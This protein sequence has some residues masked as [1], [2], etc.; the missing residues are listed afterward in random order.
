MQLEG[1]HDHGGRAEPTRTAASL[2][3]FEILVEQIPD[4]ATIQRTAE[5]ANDDPPAANA[6][7]MH[8]YVTLSN[9]LG[10]LLHGDHE[11][12]EN[13]TFTTF[14]AWAAKS[15]RPEVMLSA[16]PALTAPMHLRPVRRVFH[17]M[18]RDVLHVDH[19]I[20]RNI[21][22][23]Q[24]AIFEEIGSTIHKLIRI[25]V[26]ELDALGLEQCANPDAWPPIWRRY[27]ASLEEMLHY[28]NLSRD[29]AEILAPRSVAS[30]QRAVLPYF[31]VMMQGLSRREPSDDHRVER[32]E[33][34]LMGNV[35]LLA[36]EQRRL[37]PLLK[38]NF[39]YIP[40]AVRAR[41]EGLIGRRA[42]HTAGAGAA[43]KAS[44]QGTGVLNEAFQIAATRRFYSMALGTEDL[45]FGR[46]L[47]LPPPSRPELR[48][49]EPESDVARYR[50]GAFFPRHLEGLDA[51]ATWTVWQRHDRSLG[52]GR[53][54]AINNW[55]RY[56]ERMSFL[57]NMFR[58]RQQLSELYL[59]PGESTS[60]PAPCREPPRE[61]LVTTLTTR[62]PSV[63]I[64]A[65]PPMPTAGFLPDAV[66]D[67]L[68]GIG[69]RPAEELL[70]LVLKDL[71]I[72]SPDLDWTQRRSKFPDVLRVIGGRG[73]RIDPFL[74]DGAD[75]D[76]LIDE[77]M[78]RH[79]HDFF[80]EHGVAIFTTLFHASLPAAY[81]ARR[82]VQVLD[83]TGE[84]VSNWSQRI[85]ETG[86]FLLNVL[87]SDGEVE[88]RAGA[89]LAAGGSAAQ[90]ARRVR[91]RHQAVR[92][93]LDAP[94]NPQL[95]LLRTSGMERPTIWRVRM[96][97][98]KEDRVPTVPINQEDLLGTLGT[99]TTVTFRALE[100]LGVSHTDDDR[101]AFHHI[102]NLVGWHLGIGDTASCGD[103]RFGPH[104]TAWP[105]NEILP[106]QFREMDDLT[107]RYEARLL[108]Q[109]E[110]GSRLAKTL[111]QE[112]AY[113][114]PQFA[115]G[116]PDFLVRYMLGD[117][118]ADDLDIGD[119]GYF[120]LLVRRSGLLD[121]AATQ[122][123]RTRVGQLGVPRLSEPLTRYALRIFIAQSRGT[124][125][126][127]SVDSRIANTWGVT[128]G[129]EVRP[130]R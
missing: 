95:P 35:R 114:L 11:R 34:I 58:S 111:V 117:K 107:D 113:P 118:H 81:L 10:R 62:K 123:R 102:W 105:G 86:Q 101:R 120:Q 51:R 13:A 47:P 70:D 127:F 8:S 119:G 50:V 49:C 90:A 110:E 61:A 56:G 88:S 23:G 69:D 37:Q 115:R 100:K 66:L 52:Q 91:L 92:W 59:T 83:L 2:D 33:L 20:A 39:Q 104:A 31:E 36:Y 54:T 121:A 129:A 116:A 15:L 14:A 78:V 24:G 19:E 32:A 42:A 65:D 40:D 53:G 108:H 29:D 82:G 41:M 12:P 55:L 27:T 1:A 76:G 103:V 72:D 124:Q 25:V 106:L 80:D 38:R 68:A 93:L 128:M 26:E 71:G 44:K 75:I 6:E 18:A 122:I 22:R 17:W 77:D 16:D 43:I 74:N 7:I 46:D 28:L 87:S 96:A 98:V 94:Y 30:L 99:F 4:L 73:D 48:S 57:V 3:A 84:L 97:Q 79:A 109:S 67:Q 130:V 89:A 45:K 125:T 112:L 60:D 5:L 85:M 63:T 9:A 64:A 126:G 21:A